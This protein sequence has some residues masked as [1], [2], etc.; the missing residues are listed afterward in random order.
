MLSGVSIVGRLSSSSP[1]GA[2]VDQVAEGRRSG[3]KAGRFGC[4]DRQGQGQG[5]QAQASTSAGLT[6]RVMMSS[7]LKS[8]QEHR[9]I[10]SLN[11]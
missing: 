8:H 9:E 3:E 7:H 6:V 5:H 2:P 1:R 4:S 11:F 10:P